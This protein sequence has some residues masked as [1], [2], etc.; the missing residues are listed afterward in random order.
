M[1]TATGQ[2]STS[3]K[4]FGTG[5]PSSFNLSIFFCASLAHVYLDNVFS[6]SEIVQLQCAAASCLWLGLRFYKW[7]KY[8]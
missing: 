2:I 4:L 3:A 8:F 5:F 6:T 7:R 1:H